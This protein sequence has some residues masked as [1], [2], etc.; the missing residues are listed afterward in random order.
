MPLYEFICEHCQQTIEQ[1]CKVGETGQE[2]VC[3][4]CDERGLKR[5]LSPFSAPGTG[6]QDKCSGCPGGSC[7]SC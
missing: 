1:L 6:G 5:K 2:L 4:F 7:S 3:P